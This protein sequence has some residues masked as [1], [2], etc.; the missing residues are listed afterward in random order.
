[1]WIVWVIV[2][3]LALC[4]LAT[5]GIF[6][7]TFF[8]PKK[9]HTDDFHYPDSPLAEP[10][11]DE[12]FEL[13]KKFQS[14]PCERVETTSFD[15]L[16]L[17]ARYYKQSE[18]AP[19]AICFHGYKS[20]AI[21]DMCGGSLHL[22]DK[23]FNIL[24]CDQRA[25]GESEGRVIS[26]GINERRDVQTWCEFARRKYGPVPFY[27]VGVSM[28]AATV[29]LAADLEFPKTLRGIMA[30]CP[31][32]SPREIIKTAAG[33]MKIPGWTIIFGIL[34]A[35]VLGGFKLSKISA[36]DTVSRSKVPVLIIHGADDDFVPEEMSAE[37]A[38]ANPDKVTRLT[39]PKAGHAMSYLVDKK[40][41]I[42]AMDD[43]I[44]RTL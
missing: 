17:S 19:I 31:Y 8:Y 38:D 37:I 11:K 16:K 10:Y 23:G 36:V 22:I 35:R 15:G 7:F 6:L 44:E 1:M 2:A 21:K 13:I 12:A 9:W 25:H 29:L 42:K 30:D 18:V 32:A 4:I 27:L 41:Y 28:G 33:Y 39:I 5:V 26:F 43:F 34:G 14:L 3:L 20:T 40:T 24:L